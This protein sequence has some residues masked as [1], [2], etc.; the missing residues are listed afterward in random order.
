MP[1]GEERTYSQS[2]ARNY[3]CADPNDC[4]WDMP[5]VA[6]SA[7]PADPNDQGVRIY[8]YVRVYGTHANGTVNLF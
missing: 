8:A 5:V 2:Q 3:W 1:A 6:N 4:T 7:N